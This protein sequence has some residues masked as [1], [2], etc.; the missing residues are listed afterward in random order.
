MIHI[1]LIILAILWLSFVLAKIEINIE[2]PYG[3]AEKLPTRRLERGNFIERF[4][5]GNRP[6]T[7][8]HLWLATFIFS[9]FHFVYL[10]V[11]FNF[12]IELEILAAIALFTV[13]EDFF[14]FVFNPAY[15]IKRFRKENIWWHKDNWFLFAPKQYFVALF[16]AAAM[17]SLAQFLR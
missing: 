14:W 13:T 9:F 7:E 1:S 10:F 12:H 3:W 8:Y 4:F 2:G 11:P 5:Y 16:F 17:I 15:G 6:I